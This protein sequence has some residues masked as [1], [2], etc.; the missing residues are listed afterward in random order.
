M[1]AEPK[2]LVVFLDESAHARTRLDFALEVASGYGSHVVGIF[3]DTVPLAMRTESSSLT[4][5]RGD[6]VERAI[7][8]YFGQREKAAASLQRVLHSAARELGASAEWRHLAPHAS[9]R[10]VVVHC[11]YSDLLILPPQ[12]RSSDGQPWSSADVVFA[13]GVPGIVVPGNCQPRPIRRVLV[14]WNASRVARRAVGDAL[15]FLTRAENVTIVT[16]D[17]NVGVRG[18]GEEP[19]ADV[20]RFLT[21]HGVRTTVEQI[22]SAEANVADE[23]AR[24]VDD[25][26]VELVVAGAYGHSRM[27]EVVLG[28]T[29][30]RILHEAKVPVFISH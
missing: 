11:A 5:A 3:I 6:G 28:S 12:A 2:T 10:E 29:T 25:L 26:D 14:A 16:I 4:F 22:T 17:A 1:A 23:L 30:R 20:A 24:C 7:D 21:R 18:H 13:S 27:V 8:S 15:P 9:L 19:G